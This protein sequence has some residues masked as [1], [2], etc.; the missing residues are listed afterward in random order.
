MKVYCVVR[1]QKGAWTVEA[2]QS[3]QKGLAIAIG[4]HEVHDI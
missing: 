1:R 4:D 2:V 3:S